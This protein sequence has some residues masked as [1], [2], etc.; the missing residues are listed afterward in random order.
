MGEDTVYEFGASG[1]LNKGFQGHI[2][3]HFI[4]PEKVERLHIEMGFDKRDFTGSTEELLALCAK[5]FKGHLPGKELPM[6]AE[7]ITRLAGSLIK[8]EVNYSVFFE[9]EFL[10]TAW[11]DDMVKETVMDGKSAGRGFLPWQPQAGPL[12]IVLHA[13]SVV[14]DETAYYLKLRGER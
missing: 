5:A 2:E 10:G 1:V 11:W 12:R 7:Q 9:D 6:P 14:N 13:L 8:T 4:L 3:Y